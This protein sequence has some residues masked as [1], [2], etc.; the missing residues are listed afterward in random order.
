MPRYSSLVNE[1]SPLGDAKN[2]RQGPKNAIQWKKKR[3]DLKDFLRAYICRRMTLK[4][5]RNKTG[6]INDPLGQPT[7]VPAGSDC[8]LILKFWDG[9]TLWWSAS[10][11]NKTGVV[12]T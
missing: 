4:F 1:Y 6:F 9:R 2:E 12:K 10:W 3:D 7:A 11:I 8:R 5:K